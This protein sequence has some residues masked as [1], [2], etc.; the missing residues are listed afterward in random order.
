MRT[1]RELKLW[2]KQRLVLTPTPGWPHALMCFSFPFF[3]FLLFHFFFCRFILLANLQ[4]GNS[5]V[6]GSA[7]ALCSVS[8]SNLASGSW[9]KQLSSVRHEGS[10]DFGTACLSINAHGQ[11]QS[12]DTHCYMGNTKNAQLIIWHYP[13][14]PDCVRQDFFS[15]PLHSFIILCFVW[16]CS[17]KSSCCTHADPC[18]DLLG[19]IFAMV[20]CYRRQSFNVVLLSPSLLGV[21]SLSLC[22]SEI[23]LLHR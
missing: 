5:C 13:R 20:P 1:H 9:Y 7:L 3:S 12:Q 19:R 16:M 23:E 15:R 17:N 10:S 11:P 8:T 2:A 21:Q 14:G 18:S 6:H 4:Q 22:T